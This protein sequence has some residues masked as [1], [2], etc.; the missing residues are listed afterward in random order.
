MARKDVV[1]LVMPAQPLSNC[2]RCGEPGIRDG[3]AYWCLADG[4]YGEGERAGDRL[5]EP[6]DGRFSTEQAEYEEWDEADEQF[7]LPLDF[8]QVA[9]ELRQGVA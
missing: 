3:H 8:G 1:E 7:E 5:M 6:G 9:A 2:P 4:S